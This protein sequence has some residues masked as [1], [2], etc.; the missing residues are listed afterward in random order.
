MKKVLYVNPGAFCIVHG[1]DET[2]MSYAQG[3]EIFTESD[4]LYAE[5]FD[6]LSFYTRSI[7]IDSI[8]KEG[9][10]IRVHANEQSLLFVYIDRAF[11]TKITERGWLRKDLIADLAGDKEVQDYFASLSAYS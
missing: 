4:A 6:K 11:Y 8:E 1:E 7:G 9:S 5:W 3:L 10:N 2:F